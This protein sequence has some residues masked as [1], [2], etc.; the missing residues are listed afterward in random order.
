MQEVQNNKRPN[1]FYWENPYCQK[2]HETDCGREA[3]ELI[4][5]LLQ[6]YKME[7]SLNVFPHESNLTEEIKREKIVQKMGLNDTDKNVPLLIQIL[8]NSLGKKDLKEE[9]FAK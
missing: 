6:F 3:V 8:R 7:Y 1:S 5:E 9:K 2:I 4:M